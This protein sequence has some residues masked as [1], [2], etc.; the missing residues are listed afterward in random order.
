MFITKIPKSQANSESS[1]SYEI[2]SNVDNS[3]FV[4]FVHAHVVDVITNK[5][6]YLYKENYS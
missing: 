3:V 5:N 6:H 2:D 1:Y 4:Q